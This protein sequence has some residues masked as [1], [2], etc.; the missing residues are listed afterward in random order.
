MGEVLAANVA[1]AARAIVDAGSMESEA[2][3]RFGVLQ[4]LDD[5]DSVIRH[6][7]VAEAAR[8]FA[9]EPALTGHSGLDAA[10][11]A[12]ACWLAYRDGWQAPSWAR[13]PGRVARPWWFVSNSAY[14]RAWAMVQSPGEF[15]IRGVFITDTALTRV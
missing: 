8:M 11:A 10:Y 2:L 15:R 1:G 3:W 9:E 5:Y 4:L 12:M 7:G 6:Q 14:G 13:D